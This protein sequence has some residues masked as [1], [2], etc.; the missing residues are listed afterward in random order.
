MWWSRRWAQVCLVTLGAMSWP[1][2]RAAAA[3]GW[4]ACALVKQADVEAA[5]A[6]RKFEAGELGK[7]R[8]VASAKAAEVSRCT[9]TST[10]ASTRDKVTVGLLARRAPS[11]DSGVT[12]AAAKAG[13]IQLKATPVEVAGLG[14]GAYW[15][16]MGSASRPSLQLNVFRGKREW[17][18]LSASGRPVEPAAAL[19]QLKNLAL[20]TFARP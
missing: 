12:P 5:F 13:A 7:D 1:V 14:E 15:V 18:I 16:N 10:G 6:P 2:A 9:F 4:D 8:P 17:L 3:G 19:D 20:A 11:D